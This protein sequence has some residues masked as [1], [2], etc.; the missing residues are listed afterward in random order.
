MADSRRRDLERG[1]AGFGDPESR[2]RA[3][4][5][6]VRSGALEPGHVYLAAALGDEAARL[7]TPRH[8]GSDG[9]FFGV[10]GLMF[11]DG[12]RWSRRL[13]YPSNRRGLTD[14]LG[15][16]DQSTIVKMAAYAMRLPLSL[17]KNKRRLS[18]KALLGSLEAIE[19]GQLN[20]SEFAMETLGVNV[21]DHLVESFLGNE[22]DSELFTQLRLGMLEQAFSERSYYYAHDDFNSN[23]RG[24]EEEQRP[25][26]WFGVT[27]AAAYFAAAV[28]MLRFGM[29]V[30]ASA[31]RGFGIQ[32]MA[33]PN[34]A[35]VRVLLNVSV[36]MAHDVDVDVDTIAMTAPYGWYSVHAHLRD[37]F[38]PQVLL[39]TPDPVS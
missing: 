29:S 11:V 2:A 38:V 22:F 33:G 10:E 14:D 12:E 32:P 31:I 23:E 6:R 39:R 3:L 30:P 26:F 16:L 21:A 18:R 4:A 15:R 34:E 19:N 36:A 13:A 7:I 1:A 35:A 28:R 37:Q 8:A 9:D 27:G 25:N 20:M 17:R 5:A 24:S